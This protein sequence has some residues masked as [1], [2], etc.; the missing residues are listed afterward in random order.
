MTILHLCVHLRVRVRACVLVTASNDP[1]IAQSEI[2]APTFVE[3]SY[4]NKQ[5]QQCL[6]DME[7]LVLIQGE[8]VQLANR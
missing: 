8:R 1:V 2:A 5:S 4:S 7:V 6:I 3:G